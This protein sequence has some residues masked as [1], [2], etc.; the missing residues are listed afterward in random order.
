[1]SILQNQVSP[2][3][4]LWA[5]NKEMAKKTMSVL[6]VQPVMFIWKLWTS[7]SGVIGH[8]EHFQNGACIH[9]ESPFFDLYDIIRES[10][11]Q[12]QLV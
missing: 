2:F 12:P 8:K 6:M 11:F 5:F 4:V 3:R 7:T 1:M 10:L 9:F